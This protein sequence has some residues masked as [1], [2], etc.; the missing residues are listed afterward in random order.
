MLFRTLRRD[1]REYSR[2]NL[3]LLTKYLRAVG[4]PRRT[5]SAGHVQV[6]PMTNAD[7]GDKLRN[8]RASLG[9]KPLWMVRLMVDEMLP[10]SRRD[11]EI[12]TA[13]SGSC[14]GT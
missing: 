7:Y 8:P 10:S 4:K 13:A 5:T 1:S 3:M 11:T 14:D 9:Q 2:L 6:H 12:F